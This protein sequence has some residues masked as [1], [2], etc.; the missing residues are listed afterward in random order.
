M[1]FGY[2]Q[3]LAADTLK[4]YI[5]EGGIKKQKADV[6]NEP[7]NVTI[8]ATGKQAWRREGIKY[9][10]NEV[11]LDVI[12]RVNLV[13]SAKGTVLSQD[14]SGVVQMK[15]FLSGMPECRLG[16]N[17]KLLMDNED[18]N[19]EKPRGRQPSEKI[20]LD[21]VVFHQCVRLGS[22]ENDRSVSFV[23]PDGDF[24]L[25][26]Y[27]VTGEQIHLPFRLIPVVNELGRTRLEV[28]VSLKSLFDARFFGT[29]VVCKIP[30]PPN[31]AATTITVSVGKAKYEPEEGFI[32]WRI[33]RFPG[34]VE[35]KFSAEISLSS[36]T[37]DKK[38]WSRPPIELAF[39]VPMYTASSLEVRY[40]RV[41]E[42]KTNMQAVKWVRYV[43]RAGTY[44]HRI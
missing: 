28:Q 5:L 30:A 22:F 44:T 3:F 13:M 27:R 38:A 16:L 19:N 40:L 7:G 26:R 42:T 20:E 12:E 36:S 17:D 34:D 32:V 14:V 10:K 11:F 2:P 37:S 43:T 21:D 4:L 6:S 18:R 24:E 29:N 25:M 33:R 41:I 35:H 15:C 23:P 39:Q 8:Q 9:R 1:D 31:T